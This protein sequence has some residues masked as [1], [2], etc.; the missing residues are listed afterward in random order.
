M[1]GLAPTKLLTEGQRRNQ[2]NKKNPTLLQLPSWKSKDYLAT[3]L[4]INKKDS[5][6]V[7]LGIIHSQFCRLNKSTQ[8]QKDFPENLLACPAFVAPF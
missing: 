2:P 5:I 7:D 6:G 3:S 4:D 1:A 8:N